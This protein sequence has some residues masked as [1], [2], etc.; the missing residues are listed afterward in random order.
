MIT[1]PKFHLQVYFAEV[2]RSRARTLCKDRACTCPVSL[3]VVTGFVG[4]LTSLFELPVV[5]VTTGVSMQGFHDDFISLT[6]TST[7]VEHSL[8]R[9]ILPF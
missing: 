5:R 9:M 8:S 4:Q 6:V 1:C 2:F 3:R 7:D